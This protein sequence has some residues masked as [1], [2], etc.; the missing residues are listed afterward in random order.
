MSRVKKRQDFWQLIRSLRAKTEN[1]AL[2]SAHTSGD[3]V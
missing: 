1:G 3:N 2:A